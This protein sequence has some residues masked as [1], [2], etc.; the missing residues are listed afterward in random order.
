[1]VKNFAA[2][3]QCYHHLVAA[4]KDIGLLFS[5]QQVDHRLVLEAVML[6]VPEAEVCIIAPCGPS[7]IELI[8]FRH[9]RVAGHISLQQ[10][11]HP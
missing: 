5:H 10:Q 1:M 6:L 2:T 4:K 8:E 7:D 9:R 3:K 11:W